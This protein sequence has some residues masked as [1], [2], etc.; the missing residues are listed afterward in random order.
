M[1][2][3]PLPEILTQATAGDSRS[4]LPIDGFALLWL[5]LLGSA[6]RLRCLV[7]AVVDSCTLFGGTARVVLT[8]EVMARCAREPAVE[9]SL[10]V[11]PADGG[12]PT[13]YL[14]MLHSEQSSRHAIFRFC[15]VPPQDDRHHKMTAMSDLL[16]I[17]DCLWCPRPP[18]DFSYALVASLLAPQHMHDP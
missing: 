16:T 9:M 17:N 4:S 10:V 5:F 12:M 2:Q 1:H 7:M 14:C 15:A 3:C 11:I 6:S 18:N 8:A 13:T